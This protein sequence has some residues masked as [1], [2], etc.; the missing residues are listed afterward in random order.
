MKRNISQESKEKIGICSV[1]S[2]LLLGWRVAIPAWRTQAIVARFLWKS[3][4]CEALCRG[5][6]YLEISELLSVLCEDSSIYTCKYLCPHFPFP[7]FSNPKLRWTFGY[8]L[9]KWTFVSVS[10]NVYTGGTTV[11]SFYRNHVIWK[12]GYV[13]PVN[14]MNFYL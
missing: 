7:V 14:H 3:C 9:G 11:W 6:S 13:W 4:F 10:Q 12:L 8:S 5:S 2:L 1:P